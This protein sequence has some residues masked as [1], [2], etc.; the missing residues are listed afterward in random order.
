V[1]SPDPQASA[2]SPSTVANTHFVVLG[3]GGLGCPALLGLQ[4][5]GAQRITLFDHD[6]V[7]RHN[8]QR[9][10]LYSTADVGALKA[11]AAAHTLHARGT[12]LRVTARAERLS[13]SAVDSLVE[14]LDADATV[15]ECTDDPAIKFAL[16]DAGL[17]HGRRV[18]IAAAL[19]WRGQAIAVDAR[20]A[21]YR[22]IYEAPPAAAAVPTCAEAGVIGASVGMLGFVAAHL[23]VQLA[24][25]VR[26]VS[27]RLHTLDLLSGDARPLH[28]AI[29]TGCPGP[30]AVAPAAQQLS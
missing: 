16:N 10:V 23:A 12:G 1:L 21:C 2:P 11:T 9:Q 29:R 28:P 18:V 27:G 22:C 13:P 25:G 17:R 30:H 14:G 5:A 6:R 19:G 8:L 20:A 3:A 7:E 26:E 15:L 4:M 24:S